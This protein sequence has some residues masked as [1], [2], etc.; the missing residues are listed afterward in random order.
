MD[1]AAVDG[2]ALASE[3]EIARQPENVF[4]CDPFEGPLFDYLF[5]CDCRSDLINIKSLA[6]GDKS[7]LAQDTRS[8]VSFG[9]AYGRDCA[10]PPYPVLL[11]HGRRCSSPGT[12]FADTLGIFVS[13]LLSISM[14]YWVL[15]V[16]PSRPGFLLD[17]CAGCRIARRRG[18]ACGCIIHDA[19]SS[20]LIVVSCM[21]WLRFQCVVQVAQRQ[22]L[23]IMNYE[24]IE[25][26]WI[27]TA[28]EAYD[29]SFS[30]LQF[31]HV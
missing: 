29:S 7:R 1:F 11:H 22:K 18:H 16:G 6:Y 2:E 25:A 12:Q 5:A 28:M 10:Q 4:V 27:H 20:S 17:G 9:H 19:A 3:D 13:T 14:L 24:W 31:V 30:F 21:R 8:K 23:P 15:C 26:C